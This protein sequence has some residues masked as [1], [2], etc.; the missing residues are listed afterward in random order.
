MDAKKLVKVIKEGKQTVYVKANLDVTND[1]NSVE[2]DLWYSTSLDLGTNL[3]TE[4]AAMS[5]SFTADHM[6]KPLFTPRIATFD[7]MTCS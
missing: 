3:A 2:V 1:D 6:Q 7:C 4:L 5:M